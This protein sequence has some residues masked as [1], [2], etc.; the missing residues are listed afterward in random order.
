MS[1]IA[2]IWVFLEFVFRLPEYFIS[3]CQK[4]LIIRFIR[5]PELKFYTR[6]TFFRQPESFADN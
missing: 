1:I 4:R 2:L 3:G 6:K 5:L